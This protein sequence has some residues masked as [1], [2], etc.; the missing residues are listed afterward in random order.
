M[1][2]MNGKRVLWTVLFLAVGSALWAQ[3]GTWEKLGERTVKHRAERDEIRVTIKDGRFRRIK[4]RVLQRP[5]QFF[6]VKVH[7]A[8]GDVQD[9][10]M[11]NRI[12]AGGETRVIDL[13]GG[14]RVIQ[15]VV[16][17]YETETVRKGRR[18]KV[19]LWGFH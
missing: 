3:K 11:R 6:D 1:K 2:G 8:N 7:F 13:K 16:F 10:S 17:R 4:L 12:K 5:V 18:A 14:N 9:I 19:Q 15:K